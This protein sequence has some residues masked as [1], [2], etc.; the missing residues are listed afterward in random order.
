MQRSGR[1]R[2]S[3]PAGISMAASRSRR[4]CS[5]AGV[6]A[7]I[8]PS[9]GSITSDVCRVLVTSVPRS[10]QIWL[11]PP[12]AID[13]AAAVDSDVLGMSPAA[14]SSRCA[15]WSSRVPS[16]H[17]LRAAASSICAT[18]SSVNVARSANSAG[19]SSGVSV[20]SA[21]TPCRSGW[22]NSVRKDV[23]PPA[24]AGSDRS[25]AGAQ[26]SAATAT[27]A[28]ATGRRLPVHAGD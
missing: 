3:G 7:G 6:R 17:R 14:S 18:S 19:R 8:L 28:A 23:S 20:W 25:A 16:F 11:K 26:P 5:P 21:Q 2:S 12:M 27:T 10:Y 4:R 13:A 15:T 22:P 9:G 1:E 24:A